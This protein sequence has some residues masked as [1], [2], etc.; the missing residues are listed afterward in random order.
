MSRFGL[1]PH[2][3]P[4][5]RA[6]AQ[7]AHQA[8]RQLEAQVNGLTRQ[9]VRKSVASALL[10]WQQDAGQQGTETGFGFAP[11]VVQNQRIG[12][13]TVSGTVWKPEPRV[14]GLARQQARE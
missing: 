9:R 14:Y 3:Q 6:S 13:A 7:L 2:W 10:N 5:I 4:A 8:K 11:P 1:T 12:L